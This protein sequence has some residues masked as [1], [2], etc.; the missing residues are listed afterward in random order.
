MKLI[1]FGLLF[2][3]VRTATVD[4]VCEL[5]YQ[6]PDFAANSLDFLVDMLND[7]VESVRLNAINSLWKISKHIVLREDQLETVLAVL[8][9]KC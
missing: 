9:V 5:A 6:N 7:E 2:I 4:S 8:E 3:E 1:D